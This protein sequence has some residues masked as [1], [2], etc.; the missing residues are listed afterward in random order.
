MKKDFVKAKVETWISGLKSLTEIAKNE[1]QLAY[2]A[3]TFG[4]SMRWLFV[5]RTMEN[6]S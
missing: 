6:I 1:P 5:M 3:F 4:L 2:S